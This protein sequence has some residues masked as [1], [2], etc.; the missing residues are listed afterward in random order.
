M[1]KLDENMNEKIGLQNW[2]MKM[3]EIWTNNG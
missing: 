2:T 3:D 1:K